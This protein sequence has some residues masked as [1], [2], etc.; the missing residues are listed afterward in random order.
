MAGIG[1]HASPASAGPLLMSWGHDFCYIWHVIIVRIK[2][3]PSDIIILQEII[4]FCYLKVET[5]GPQRR[6][7]YLYIAYFAAF[8]TS[9]IKA[10]LKA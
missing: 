6:Y 1:G 9:I 10:Y 2:Y 4:D 7:T 8:S 3:Q 5:R